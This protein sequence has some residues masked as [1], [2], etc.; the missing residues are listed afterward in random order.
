MSPLRQSTSHEGALCTQHHVEFNGQIHVPTALLRT[1]GTKNSS[2]RGQE[3]IS[4][5][6]RNRPNSTAPSQ[7]IYRL[8]HPSSC[9]TIKYDYI[10]YSFWYESSFT[11]AECSYHK[12]SV[13]D[14][15][16]PCRAT[17][18]HLQI[19][20]NFYPFSCCTLHRFQKDF[21]NSL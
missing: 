13:T 1:E 8:H 10:L 18:E 16:P 9:R 14:Q 4:C 19:C 6:A 21:G 15:R 11:H 2:G 5:P 7:S 3:H 20:M 12:V 17:Y